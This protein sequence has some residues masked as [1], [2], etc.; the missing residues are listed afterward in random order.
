DAKL[1]HKKGGY[2]YF[3]PQLQKKFIFL[4]RTPTFTTNTFAHNQL[5]YA[6]TQKKHRNLAYHKKLTNFASQTV[7]KNSWISFG[8]RT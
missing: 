6:F 8:L 2:S 5:A 4:P 3:S 1:R 7:G